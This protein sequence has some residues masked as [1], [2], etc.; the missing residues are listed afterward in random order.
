MT[1]RKGPKGREDSFVVSDDGSTEHGAAQGGDTQWQG[2]AY[3]T[4]HHSAADPSGGLV[5]PSPAT[6]FAGQ[7]DGVGLGWHQQGGYGDT[8][9]WQ[10]PQM[11]HHV[12]MDG[13]FVSPNGANDVSVDVPGPPE[14]HNTASGSGSSSPVADRASTEA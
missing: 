2:L 3:G 1:Q 12:A 11:H 8:G 10:H 4:Y 9:E 5:P 7:G 13:S 6:Q 14:V